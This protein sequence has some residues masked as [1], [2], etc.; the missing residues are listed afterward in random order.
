MKSFKANKDLSDKAA[1]WVNRLNEGLSDS[2]AEAF[3]KWLTNNEGSH[4]MIQKYQASW[5]RL[6]PLVDSDF[7]D[8]LLEED[9]IHRHRYSNWYLKAGMGIAATLILSL[10]IALLYNNSLTDSARQNG[11]ITASSVIEDYVVLED[12]ST[13][14][15]NAES[16]VDYRYSAELRE[17]WLKSGEA[18]FTVSKDPDRAFIVYAGETVTRAIGTQFNIKYSNEKVEVMV[19]EGK[20]QFSINTANKEVSSKSLGSGR[21]ENLV[22]NQKVILS[23]N[24]ENGSGY[25]IDRLNEIEIV[26]AIAWKPVTLEFESTQLREVVDTFNQYNE[27]KLVIKDESIESLVVV[28]TFRSNKWEGFV[29]LL[30][31]TAGINA[32][33]N[34]DEIWLTANEQ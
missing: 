8:E 7:V 24:H 28:A 26:N 25:V 27:T 21:V 31:A 17:F 23:R 15:L 30:E 1:E 10:S 20:V 3:E 14:E 19:T 32:V 16:V 2:E 18:F 33:R 6:E 22:A 11:L 13:I 4:D 5:N 12:D 9:T 34:G 29:R